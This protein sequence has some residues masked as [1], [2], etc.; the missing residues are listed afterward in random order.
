[1]AKSERDLWASVDDFDRDPYL[2]NFTNATV[3]L[4]TGSCKQ[5]DPRDMI[6]CLVPCAYNPYA[7]A[8]LWQ[9]L[10][11]RCTQC[12]ETGGTVEFLKRALGY[13]LVGS[14]PQQ[15][16]FLFV[17]PKR[18]GKSKVLEISVRALGSDYA[19]VS[20]PKLITRSRWNTH[21]DSGT[22]SIRG[23]AMPPA[24]AKA[25]SDFEND[26]DHVAEFIKAFIDFGE[27]RG[28][29]VAVIAAL[30]FDSSRYPHSVLLAELAGNIADGI[31]A[32]GLRQHGHCT[33]GSSITAGPTATQ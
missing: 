20:Q 9:R 1:M 25:T 24:V 16:F 31:F 23:L 28:R 14:N 18:T 29:G 6:S 4:R 8:P 26:N 7:Q 2:L 11:A 17:G 30:Q 32:V 27:N 12:D 10:I 22:W 13:M 15:K 33:A 3:D 19:A 5:H 21:H